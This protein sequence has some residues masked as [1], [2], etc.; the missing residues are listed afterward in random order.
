MMEKFIKDQI[1][2]SVINYKISKLK[3]KSMQIMFTA[4]FYAICNKTR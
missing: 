2:N 4:S 3:V 1:K